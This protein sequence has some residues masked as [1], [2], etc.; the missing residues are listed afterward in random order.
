MNN[1]PE[2]RELVKSLQKGDPHSMELLFR[3]L[4]PRLCAFANKFL[5]DMDDAEDIVQEVFFKI[6]KN[7]ARLD[8]NKSFSTYLFSA[9]KNSA[10]NYLEHRKHKDKYAE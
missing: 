10:I 3:R 9:V 6:W 1:L 8:E 2:Y 4:Y 5:H 7:R